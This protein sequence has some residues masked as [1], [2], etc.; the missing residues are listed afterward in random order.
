MNEFGKIW[1]TDVRAIKNVQIV[2]DSKVNDDPCHVPEHDDLYCSERWFTKNGGYDIT[3]PNGE[4]KVTLSFVEIFHDGVGDR[5]FNIVIEGQPLRRQY[6][7]SKAA[8]EKKDGIARESFDVNVKDGVL[9]IEFLKVKQHPK[10][11]A[12]EIT[13]VV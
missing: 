13:K 7:I 10:I 2:G 1:H 9:N 8:A 6:D 12:V 5:I 11:S 4:Y 3:V